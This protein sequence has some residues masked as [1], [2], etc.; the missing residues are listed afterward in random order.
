VFVTGWQDNHRKYS[1]GLDWWHNE[2]KQPEL[3]GFRSADNIRYGGELLVRCEYSL[4]GRYY[5]LWLV[6]TTQR[7][8][9]H[10][11]YHED[12]EGTRYSFHGLR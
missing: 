3:G 2:Q 5:F 12:H 10:I 1:R 4:F 7:R 11:F 6:T 9:H 8:F